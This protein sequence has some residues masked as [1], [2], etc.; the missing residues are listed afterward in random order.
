MP[1]TTKDM[2]L[3]LLSSVLVS[4]EQRMYVKSKEEN[5]VELETAGTIDAEDAQLG[6]APAI[7]PIEKKWTLWYEKKS[8]EQSN[9]CLK[10]DDYLNQLKKGGTFQSLPSFWKYW[11][12]VQDVCNVPNKTSG[13]NYHLFKNNIKPVWEDPKN[14]KGG[15]WTIVFPSGTSQQEV[16]KQWIS[17]MLTLL[18]GEIGKDSSEINGAVLSVRSWGSMISIWNRHANSKHQNL[19]EKIKQHF[20][21]DSIKYQRHQTTMRRNTERAKSSHPQRTFSGSSEEYTSNSDNSSSE[22]EQE[23]L[24]RPR[25]IS[26]VNDATK[27]M[28]RELILGLQDPIVSEP[29]LPILESKLESEVIPTLPVIQ[30]IQEAAEEKQETAESPDVNDARSKRRRRKVNSTVKKTVIPAMAPQQMQKQ[31]HSLEEKIVVVRTKEAV[32]LNKLGWG[33]VIA[34]GIASSVLSW[35]YY[36]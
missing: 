20:G 10:K 21:V 6:L 18:L 35:A 8:D 29:T 5:E 14:I 1:V 4:S 23:K 26:G 28:L 2:L 30:N 19:E 17:F 31:Q 34:V 7:K 16:T 9:K 27:E 22:G 15:K 32:P 12:E 33:L 11:N 25:K 36:L 24:I 3:F 13:A